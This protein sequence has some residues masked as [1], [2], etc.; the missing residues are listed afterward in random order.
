MSEKV[1]NIRYMHTY[2]YEC[3]CGNNMKSELHTQLSEHPKCWICKNKMDLIFYL[4]SSDTRA[5]YF[6]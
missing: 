6:K 2:E 4:R 1:G 3:A 5:E